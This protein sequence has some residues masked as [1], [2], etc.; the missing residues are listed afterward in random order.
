MNPNLTSNIC[1]D[2]KTPLQ[3]LDALDIITTAG[4]ARCY[5]CEQF[6]RGNRPAPAT[7]APGEPSATITRQIDQPRLRD[8][9]QTLRAPNQSALDGMARRAA[10]VLAGDVAQ[11]LDAV[12]DIANHGASAGRVTVA[13]EQAA[14]LADTLALFFGATNNAHGHEG[15]RHPCTSCE[16][17]RGG[18]PVTAKGGKTNRRAV[19]RA[20]TVNV[21]T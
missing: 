18:T 20:P 5:K 6:A 14:T 12:L 13:E 17:K 1:A 4:V 7:L 3:N 15:P 16:R 21:E 19:P 10:Q 9:D 2:C 8:L 11:F